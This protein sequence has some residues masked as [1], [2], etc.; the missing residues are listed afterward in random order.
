MI[1]S[2]I[3]DISPQLVKWRRS[4]HREPELGFMEYITTYKIGKEL[5][6]LGYTIYLGRDVMQDESRLGVPENKKLIEQ[7]TIAQ[8]WGVEESWLYHMR[9]GFTGV[10]ATIDTR[11]TGNHLSFRFDIDALPIDECKES[12]HFPSQHHF[13]SKFRNVMHACGHDGH[14]TIGLGLAAFIAKYINELK[15][16]YTLIFQPAEEG[17]RGAKAIV[18]KG[19]LDDVDYFY[20]GHIG[21]QPLAV[22][23]VAATTKGFLA[24]TKLN[25]TFKGE[26]SHAGM[27]PELGKNALL[28]AATAVSNLYAIPRH[29]EGITRINVGKLMAGNGRNIIADNSKME[30]ETRGITRKVNQYMFEE[31]KRIIESA[32]S[33][34][35]VHSHIEEV[36]S[37]NEIVCS[38]ELISHI[39]ACCTNGVY[40]K[41]IIPEITVMGSEDAS[42]MVDQVQKNGGKATYMLFGTHLHFPHHHPRFDFQEELLPAALETFIRIVLAE[43]TSS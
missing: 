24:S 41:N 12:S 3:D 26:S 23:E 18:D 29:S 15:G 9:G 8:E 25:V 11:K 22:G 27:Q 20:A 30:V 40:I 37:T 10:I 21:I 17:G 36:G 39:S 5:Q 6:R 33:M 1:A 16:R 34:H 19:W 43:R 31:A 38:D 42:Y 13:A 28:A 4:F 32:A 2:F 7:E 35:G 14:M